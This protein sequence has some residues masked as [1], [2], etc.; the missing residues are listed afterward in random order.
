MHIN[1]RLALG[2]VAAL[3]FAE[4]LVYFSDA[5]W[6]KLKRRLRGLRVGIRCGATRKDKQMP[7]VIED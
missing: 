1:F 7:K 6:P 5:I 3:L 2:L 4:G